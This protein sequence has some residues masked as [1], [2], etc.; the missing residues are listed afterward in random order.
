MSCECVPYSRGTV[1]FLFVCV[2][3]EVFIC[4]GVP[5]Y[6]GVPFWPLLAP[7]LFVLALIRLRLAMAKAA[8]ESA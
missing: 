8:D 4:M 7:Y 2:R 5:L 1:I 3:E 6:M